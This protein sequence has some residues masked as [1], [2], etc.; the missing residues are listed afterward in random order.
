MPPKRKINEGMYISET[1]ATHT[2][3]PRHE[4]SVGEGSS[5]RVLDYLTQILQQQ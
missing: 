1:S 3:D 4:T 2:G 5:T